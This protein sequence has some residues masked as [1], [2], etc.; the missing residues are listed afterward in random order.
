MKKSVGFHTKELAKY[1]DCPHSNSDE[2]L[3]CLRGKPA[4][5]VV[6]F[7]KEIMV[8]LFFAKWTF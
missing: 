4:E 1:L 8:K 5:Q 7:Q 3:S 6:R 2:M